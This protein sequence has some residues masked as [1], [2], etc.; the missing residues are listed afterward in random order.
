MINLSKCRMSFYNRIQLEILS[1]YST[2]CWRCWRCWRWESDIVGLPIESAMF[3][4]QCLTT[5]NREIH[6]LLFLVLKEKVPKEGDKMAWNSA[7]NVPKSCVPSVLVL[8]W[9]TVQCLSNAD[10]YRP[11]KV[12]QT[13]QGV[14]IFFF[15]FYFIFFFFF[16]SFFYLR[17]FLLSVLSRCLHCYFLKLVLNLH[18]LVLR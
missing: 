8:L 6:P 2:D 13:Q 4:G 18:S 17:L 1:G 12:V 15:F 9:P 11:L 5:L 14:S 3:N 10:Y 7:W 16:F